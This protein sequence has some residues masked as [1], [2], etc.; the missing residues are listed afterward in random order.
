LLIQ[1]C[2]NGWQLKWACTYVQGLQGQENG[3]LK[4]IK[5][6]L[7]NY[8]DLTTAVDDGMHMQ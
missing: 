1:S 6:K 2:S 3:S 5:I 4:I 8:Y 7:M